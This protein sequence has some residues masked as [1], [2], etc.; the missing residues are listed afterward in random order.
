MICVVRADEEVCFVPTKPGICCSC[1]ASTRVTSFSLVGLAFSPSDDYSVP[2]RTINL[3]HVLCLPCLNRLH[4]VL[5]DL[6]SAYQC[7]GHVSEIAP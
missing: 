3:G 5:Q 1:G 2:S 7:K 4:E 6:V